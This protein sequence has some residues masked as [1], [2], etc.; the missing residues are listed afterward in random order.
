MNER[1]DEKGRI[2]KERNNRSRES[3]KGMI[4]RHGTK[5]QL[6]DSKRSHQEKNKT[7]KEP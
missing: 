7:K 3:Y 2:R 4:V 1:R 6:R 5:I